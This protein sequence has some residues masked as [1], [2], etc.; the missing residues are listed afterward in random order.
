MP[1][2]TVTC[3]AQ[4]QTPAK[5]ST[6]DRFEGSLP[7]RLTLALASGALLAMAAAAILI[8]WHDSATRVVG[9]D[10]YKTLLQFLLV[11][12]LG[13]GVS[14]LYQAFNRQAEQRAERFKLAEDR[15]TAIREIRQRYLA[16]LVVLYNAV[17][18]ARRLLRARAQ[19][20]TTAGDGKLRVATYDEQLQ[21]LL[22]AQLS[23]ELMIRNVNAEGEVFHGVPELVL[24]LKSTEE[25]LRELITEYETVMPRVP[26]GTTEIP[27]PPKLADFI[28][29]Y[30]HSEFRPDFIRPV[31]AAMA[32]V[33]SLITAPQP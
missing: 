6:I 20:H 12:V 22:D 5:L 32:A 30:E 14:L 9:A 7:R 31:Q 28:G 11:V 1:G 19:I 27:T 24:F 8:I 33:Q 16:E 18:R 23:L 17:K 25:Y 29:P 4:R 10:G 21:L 2:R 13:G 3:T 15:A 26:S